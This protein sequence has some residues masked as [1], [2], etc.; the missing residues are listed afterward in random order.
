V[1]DSAKGPAAGGATDGALRFRLA[2][3]P[4]EIPASA[5]LLPIAG[6]F[7]SGRSPSA[8]AAWVLVVLASVL[9]HEL[10][11][12][13]VMRWAGYEPRI[14]L[15]WWGGLTSWPEGATPTAR[16]R[17]RISLAGP[18]AG[19]AIGAVAWAMSSAG[20]TG[21]LARVVLGDLVWVNLW[22]SLLN[23]APV[24]PFDG[25]LAADALAEVAT[26]VPRHRLVGALGAAVG[27]AGVCWAILHQ[28]LWIGYLAAIGVAKS[29]AQWQAGA[30]PAG[31]AGAARAMADG[32]T[33]AAR[34]Q[35]TRALAGTREDRL[36][37]RLAELLAWCWLRDCNP[38]A[39]RE[40]LEAMEGWTPSASV[41]AHVAAAEGRHG[42]VIE[43]LA[44]DAIRGAL[45]PGDGALL[46][47]AHVVLGRAAELDRLHEQASQAGWRAAE[48]LAHRGS[49]VLFR[50][51]RFEE[52]LA[53]CAR[54][55]PMSPRHAY[56]AACCCARLGRREEALAWLRQA[57]ARG[58]R[59]AGALEDPD[60]ELVHGCPELAALVGSG[61]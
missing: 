51:G 42:Q 22:W 56:N 48:V 12:A 53:I 40:A 18:A 55:A 20:F 14:A 59:D 35:L 33:G 39:A 36:R 6:G 30:V 58:H 8:A 44:P 23:L 28:Q 37:A 5:L 13:L 43:L 27:A 10:G 17:L 21:A 32:R 52:A 54:A 50:A 19:L 7:S 3:I 29:W 47:Y 49:L 60:L 34:A 57:L 1:R 31:I 26:G 45:S 24:L 61:S 4:V 2:G 9:W 41:R 11:H 15:G 16:Q 46:A 25:G 38:Q